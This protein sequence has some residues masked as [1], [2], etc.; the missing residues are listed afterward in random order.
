MLTQWSDELAA[1]CDKLIYF[2]GEGASIGYGDYLLADFTPMPVAATLAVFAA[3]TY[4]TQPSGVFSTP[5]Q[6]GVFHL[7]ERRRQTGSGRRQRP[8]GRCG[9]APGRGLIVDPDHR[10]SRKRNRAAR[11]KR[12]GAAA[13]RAHALF[14]RGSQPRRA[15]GKPRPRRRR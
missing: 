11:D 8:S 12:I 2:G 1:G 15:Q 9:G 4:D 10:L 6:A 14:H 3:K 5:D 13:A 7:F